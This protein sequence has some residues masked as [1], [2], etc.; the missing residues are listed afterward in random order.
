VNSGR[1]A[2]RSLDFSI[3]SAKP[4]PPNTTAIAP[5]RRTSIGSSGTSSSTASATG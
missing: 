2:P 4:S 5:R 3:R 1:P